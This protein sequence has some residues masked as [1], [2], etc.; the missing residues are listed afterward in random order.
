MPISFKNAMD[1]PL[2]HPS[3]SFER[4]RLPFT[5]APQCRVYRPYAIKRRLWLQVIQS[6]QVYAAAGKLPAAAIVAGGDARRAACR[7]IFMAP[8]PTGAAPC[9]DKCMKLAAIIH[10]LLL[11]SALLGIF[12][13]PVSIGA[14]GSTMAASV[15]THMTA[16]PEDMSCCPGEASGCDGVACPMA[17]L[18][19]TAFVGHA[20]GDTPV[21]LTW[22]TH[23]FLSVPSPVLA[24]SLVDPPS[25]PPRV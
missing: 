19:A 17:L 6:P 7:H 10:R 25:R 1:W 16:M 24:S 15:S 21:N 12:F 22:T 5:P 13:G 9:H 3:R 8:L 14:A 4:I 20:A 18:C 2:I 11:L 23:R